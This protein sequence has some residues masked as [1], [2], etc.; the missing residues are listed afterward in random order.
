MNGNDIDTIEWVHENLNDFCNI[1][2]E[3]ELGLIRDL[4]PEDTIDQYQRT[5]GWLEKTID[6]YKDNKIVV[7]THHAPS[8]Q[9]KRPTK[10]TLSPNEDFYLNGAYSSDLENFIVERP[11]IKFWFHGH[12]HKK[13]NYQIGSTTVLCNPRGY[14]GVESISKEFE[15]MV[16]DV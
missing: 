13:H 5:L 4:E 6:E 9:S 14:A 16:V 12:T 10:S 2:F 1:T 3:D 7:V 15:W 8:K 11:Q